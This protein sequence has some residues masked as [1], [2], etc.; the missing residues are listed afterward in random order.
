MQAQFYIPL[1]VRYGNLP[2]LL[3]PV[4]TGMLIVL[5]DHEA[6]FLGDFAGDLA[7]DD[8]LIGDFGCGDL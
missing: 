2:K 4:R 6:A 5:D 7:A 3:T 1:A 8:L